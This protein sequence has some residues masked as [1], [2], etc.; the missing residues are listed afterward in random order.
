MAQ[1]SSS[2]QVT[3]EEDKTASGLYKELEARRQPFL[4]RARDCAKLTIPSVLPPQ[5]HGRH[6]KLPTPYQSLGARGINNLS[7]K[8]LPLP[9]WHL[10]VT[11]ETKLRMLLE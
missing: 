4:D 11:S 10:V 1:Y 8:L 5:S 9:I 3:S 2:S 7:S 6:S